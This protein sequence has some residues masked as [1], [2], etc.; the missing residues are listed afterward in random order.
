MKRFLVSFLVSGFLLTFNSPSLAHDRSQNSGAVMPGINVLVYNQAQ[1]PWQSLDRA[2]KEAARIFHGAGIEVV[3]TNCNTAIT[4]IPNG[5]DCTREVGP[6]ELMLRILPEI[7]VA[8]GVTDDRTMGFAFG[9]LASVSFCRVRAEAAKFGVSP[10]AVLGPAIAHEIGHLLLA[11]E[12]HSPAG[13][14][15]ARWQRRDYEAPTLGALKFT[16]EQAGQVRAE[17]RERG[18]QQAAEASR[19]TVSSRAP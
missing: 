10:Y 3:W 7:G 9:N 15:R 5:V 2:E 16:A 19:L 4:G 12:G 8:P 13:I 14:M 17:V 11:Q 1:V 6:S 18:R